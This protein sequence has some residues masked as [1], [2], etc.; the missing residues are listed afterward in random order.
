ML[1]AWLEYHTRQYRAFS[2]KLKESTLKRVKKWK[3]QL[4]N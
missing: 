3:L 1:P 4:R 2:M